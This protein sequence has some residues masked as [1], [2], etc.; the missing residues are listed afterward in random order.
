M[1]AR[2]I[3]DYMR[4]FRQTNT[5]HDVEKSVFPQPKLFIAAVKTIY[6]PN[7]SVLPPKL[8]LAS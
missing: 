2:E 7:E 5:K 6:S 1:I 3:Y 8:V 4:M